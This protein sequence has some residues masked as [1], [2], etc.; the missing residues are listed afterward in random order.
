MA[1]ISSTLLPFGHFLNK[2]ALAG[3]LARR[4]RWPLPPPLVVEDLDTGFDAFVDHRLALAPRR[5]PGSQSTIAARH[6]R[7]RQS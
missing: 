5:R 1:R 4:C 3:A 2:R 6:D 7:R